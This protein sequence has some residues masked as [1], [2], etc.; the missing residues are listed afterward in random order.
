MSLS[1]N[2]FNCS[3]QTSAHTSILWNRMGDIFSIHNSLLLIQDGE[4]H[5]SS[6]NLKLKNSLEKNQFCS[7]SYD[8]I[9]SEILRIASILNLQTNPIKLLKEIEPLKFSELIQ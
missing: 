9:C 7:K 3:S 1:E 5:F 2:W 6:S 4:V 8:K